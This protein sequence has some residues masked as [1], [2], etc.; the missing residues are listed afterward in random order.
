MTL[1]R[2][3]GRKLLGMPTNTGIGAML[4]LHAVFSVHNDIKLALLNH[5]ANI[6]YA[7]YLD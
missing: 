7:Q 6:R 2:V 5:Y 1:Q 4:Y 3:D